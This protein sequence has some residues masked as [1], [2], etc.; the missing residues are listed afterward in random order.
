MS[1]YIATAAADSGFTRGAHVGPLHH[2]LFLLRTLALS[3]LSGSLSLISSHK[4]LLLRPL[5]HRG[6]VFLFKIVKETSKWGRERSI[7]S[8]CSRASTTRRQHDD[9]M[10][11][12]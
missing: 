7:D 9:A 2:V 4:S 10:S 11:E 3:P 8:L 12:V 6:I 5:I 1:H